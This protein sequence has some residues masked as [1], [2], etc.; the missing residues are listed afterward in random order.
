MAAEEHPIIE[1]A[2]SKMLRAAELVKRAEDVLNSVTADDLL[3]EHYTERPYGPDDGGDTSQNA[4][5]LIYRVYANATA[6]RVVREHLSL[7]FLS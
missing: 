4:H 5:N 2:S 1:T 7:E 3:R 6:L